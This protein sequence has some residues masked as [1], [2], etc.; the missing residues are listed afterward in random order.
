MAVTLLLACGEPKGKNVS[1]SLTAALGTKVLNIDGFGVNITPAQWH[2]GN[3]KPVLDLLVDDLGATLFRFDCTGLADWLDPAM[4]TAGGQWHG[5]YLD[6]VYRSKVFTDAWE[7]FRYLNG[8]GIEPFFNVSGRNHP[9]LGHPD[10]PFML[11][12][13]DS[14]AEMVA[15]MLKWAREKEQL[16]FSLVAPFNETDLGYPEGP[17]IKGSDML[18]ATRFMVAA[19]ERHGLSDVRIIAIDD[20]IPQFDKLGAVLSDSTLA[21]HIAV[22]ATH[23]Y[24]NGDIGENEPWFDAETP[25]ARFS[26][27]IK[28]SAFKDASVWMSEYG[29]LDQTGLIEYEFAW[30]STR[31]LMKSMRDGFNAA[32]AWDAFDNFHE[33]DTAWAVYGLLRTD[34]VNWT[35]TPKKRYFAAKQIYRFVRPGW[36]MVEI[37][38]PKPATFDVYQTWH[39]AFRHLRVQAFVSPDGRDF[40][41]VIMNSIESDVELSMLLKNINPDL[42]S[43]SLHHFITDRQH[44]CVM[45]KT[46]DIRNGAIRAVLPANSISTITTLK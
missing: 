29:D 34:T 1:L 31:R 23:T 45:K 15:T 36:S 22:F 10:N 41:A 8:K 46:P 33:H 21:G 16:N 32:M 25:Y 14:Y 18:T 20:A 43:A 7:T 37:I 4:R 28:N 19:L 12:D 44:N 6:S 9:G 2:E 13:F 30:R 42:L 17:G 24:G 11:T 5:P 39:D 40:T 38:T 26:K 27:T 3:L 35:Y